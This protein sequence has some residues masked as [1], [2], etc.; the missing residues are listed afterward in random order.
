MAELNLSAM[1]RN[2]IQSMEMLEKMASPAN[3]PLRIRERD[4]NI[5]LGI[6]D[7]PTY[8]FEK[9]SFWKDLTSNAELETVQAIQSYVRPFLNAANFKTDLAGPSNVA[10]IK[11][12]KKQIELEHNLVA[13]VSSTPPVYSKAAAPRSKNYKDDYCLPH[14]ISKSFFNLN[15]Q[16]PLKVIADVYLIQENTSRP[17]TAKKC[18]GNIKKISAPEADA[19]DTENDY[20][21]YY[22]AQLLSHS[23]RVRSTVV[24]ELISDKTDDRFNINQDGGKL[25]AEDFIKYMQEHHGKNVSV[26]LIQPNKPP[27]VLTWQQKLAALQMTADVQT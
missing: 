1:N 5:Y 3:G 10:L 23:G 25:A 13:R 4:G 20:V 11:L 6:R 21:K 9:A 24:L 8:F 7:W 22:F 12:S 26:M 17:A 18:K 2:L 19:L 27:A 14:G 16:S 15:S